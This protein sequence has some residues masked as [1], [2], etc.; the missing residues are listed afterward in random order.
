VIAFAQAQPVVIHE[1]GGW[2]SPTALTAYAT[3]ALAG[4]TFGLAVVAWRSSQHTKRALDIAQQQAD[5]EAQQAHTA[6]EAQR[7]SLHPWLSLS[8]QPVTSRTDDGGLAVRAAVLS[9]GPGWARIDRG[10]L[11][12]PSGAQVALE[13]GV[14]MTKPD[15]REG[16]TAALA[17]DDPRTDELAATEFPTL[18][19]RCT[20]I[21]GEQGQTYTWVRAG[22]EWVRSVHADA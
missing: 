7:V 1:G 10:H 20:N 22:S 5:T 9:I 8:D 21:H 2:L 17:R 13:P 16:L 11:E 6:A 12:L 4:I 15:G 14:G 18:V 3:F 19:V